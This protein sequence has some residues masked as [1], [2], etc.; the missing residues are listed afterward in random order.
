[1]NVYVTATPK[2]GGPFQPNKLDLGNIRAAPTLNVGYD[3][4]IGFDEERLTR[5]MLNPTMPSDKQRDI[6]G[7]LQGADGRLMDVW[8]WNGRP[9]WADIF[10][11]VKQQREPDVRKIG[12][13][14]CGTPVIGK[15]LKRFCIE[16]SSLNEGIAF[17][18]HKENF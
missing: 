5:A 1:M 2:K 14:F 15:D 9:N 8:V 13:C 10:L 6:Q 16:N 7:T 18:L 12:C 3:V 11:S 17:D 4:D